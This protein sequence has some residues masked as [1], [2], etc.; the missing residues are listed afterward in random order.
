MK[1]KPIS[2]RQTLVE[3]LVLKHGRF[4]LLVS[5]AAAVGLWQLIIVVTGLP[6]FILPSPGQVVE[7]MLRA[8]AD[9]SLLRHA[10]ITLVEVLLGLL[11]GSTLATGLGY[12]LAK[13]RLL[14]R[15]ASPYLVASQAIPVVAVAPLLVIWFGTG[16][17]AKVLV[18]MLTVFFP[19]LVNTVV[20]LRSVP[21]NLRDVM[22]SLHAS[23]LEMLRHLEIPAALPVLLGGLRVGATLSVIGAVV[24]EFVV[25]DAGLGFLV[26]ISG[27]QYDTAMV[28]G[29]IFTLVGMAL[30]LYGL[31]VLAERRLL[32]WQK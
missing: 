1:I 3:R 16:L 29:A 2:P 11:A 31:V 6:A 12:L 18:C 30:A 21:E 4:L 22:H 19:I 20:G 9:G 25:A 27:W 28:F 32:R 23:R 15:V 26:N 14:E 13:S 5:L 8:V 24:G 7:R 17:L 10:S